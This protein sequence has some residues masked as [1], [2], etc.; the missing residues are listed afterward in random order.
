MSAH[1]HPTELSKTDDRR[2]RIVWSDGIEQTI[3]FRTLR[4]GCRCATCMEKREKE[5]TNPAPAG[6]LPVLSPA[7]ARPL[8]IEKMHP[9]GNYAY[10][11]HFSDGHSSGIYTFEMLRKTGHSTP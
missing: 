7:E 1:P 3:S 11:I 5:I 9:V 8:D 2:L 4:D 10:N 6:M